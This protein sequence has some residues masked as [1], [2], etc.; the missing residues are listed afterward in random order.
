MP[1]RRGGLLKRRSAFALHAAPR[2]VHV[3]WRAYRGQ[4]PI[5]GVHVATP[6]GSRPLPNL[7]RARVPADTDGCLCRLAALPPCLLLACSRAWLAAG[8]TIALFVVMWFAFILLVSLI[9]YG[10]GGSASAPPPGVV[11]SRLP[12]LPLYLSVYLS[13]RL[14]H[15]L[16]YI[17][18]FDP[19]SSLQCDWRIAGIRTGR[20]RAGADPHTAVAQPT[21]LYS[22]SPDLTRI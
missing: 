19:L 16:P 21:V 13:A 3:L 2:R 18:S 6:T 11:R 7:G 1:G 17:I 12:S 10:T 15:C 20:R 14:S 9:E 5:W 22:P 4:P 8:I